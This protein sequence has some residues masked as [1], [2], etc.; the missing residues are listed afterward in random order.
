MSIYTHHDQSRITYIAQAHHPTEGRAV[1]SNQSKNVKGNTSHAIARSNHGMYDVY[2]AR[3]MYTA[4]LMSLYGTQAC[5]LCTSVSAV[6][7][8][9]QNYR[10]PFDWQLR[11]DYLD[12][13]NMRDVETAHLLIVTKYMTRFIIPDCVQA[14]V[15]CLRKQMS[16]ISQHTYIHTYDSPRYRIE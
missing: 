9:T 3:P 4:L 1:V 15:R 11:K 13:D 10:P 5:V 14:L 8:L 12:P 2:S 7:L 16:Y 6:L